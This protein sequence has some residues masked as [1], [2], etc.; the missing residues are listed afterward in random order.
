MHRPLRDMLR[1]HMNWLSSSYI[2]IH[3]GIDARKSSSDFAVI[4]DN[5][6]SYLAPETS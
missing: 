2:I 3:V 1:F 4:Y 5:K 6:N